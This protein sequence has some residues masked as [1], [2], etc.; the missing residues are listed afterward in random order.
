MSD[1][2]DKHIQEHLREHASCNPRVFAKAP[3][4]PRAP[5]PNVTWKATQTE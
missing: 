4:S 3:P 5:T 2:R 1:V